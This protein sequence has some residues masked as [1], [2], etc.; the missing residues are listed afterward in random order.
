MRSLQSAITWWRHC[1]LLNHQCTSSKKRR[2]LSS[3]KDVHTTTS[4]PLCY[5]LCH[6]LLIRR[7]MFLRHQQDQKQ[8]G[9][10]M[11]MA[12]SPQLSRILPTL[13]ICRHMFQVSP[14]L[15]WIG[16][17]H[18][19]RLHSKYTCEDQASDR[20]PRMPQYGHHQLKMILMLSSVLLRCP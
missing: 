16:K 7:L 4:I 20:S 1:Q 15:I 12:K 9:K 6:L 2:T 14:Q 3:L 19:H 8:I 5:H 11:H 18:S 10:C 13:K 17:G